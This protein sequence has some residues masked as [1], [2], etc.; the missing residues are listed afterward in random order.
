[1]TKLHHQHILW[2]VILKNTVVRSTALSI[3]HTQL[4]FQHS[5]CLILSL[6]A[7]QKLLL[8][9]KTLN[10]YLQTQLLMLAFSACHLWPFL[11]T[12]TYIYTRLFSTEL[13]LLLGPQKWILKWCL[14]LG[15][16]SR[17]LRARYFAGDVIIAAYSHHTSRMKI[18]RNS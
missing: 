7:S 4:Y 5:I 17:A 9:L 15:F 14:E 16:N 12:H 13:A 18:E 1:M 6:S 3:T 2:T 10:L 11:H 8:A